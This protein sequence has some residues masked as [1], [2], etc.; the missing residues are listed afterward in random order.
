[1]TGGGLSI[2]GTTLDTEVAD[3][4]PFD[5]ADAGS[6]PDDGWRGNAYND[7]SGVTLKAQAFAI[8]RH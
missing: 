4:F 5:S 7:G 8:C 6:T 1:V 2:T 3:T